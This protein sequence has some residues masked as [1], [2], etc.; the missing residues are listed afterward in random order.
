MYRAIDTP[1]L[2]A[3]LAGHDFGGQSL[4]LALE[5]RDSFL[6]ENDGETLLHFRDGLAELAPGAAPDVRLRLGVEHFSSLIMGAVGL[7]ALR[8]YGLAEI[9]DPNYSGRVRRLFDSPAQPI[10]LTAF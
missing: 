8:R 4:S 6:P 2:F 5:L 3:A 9:D 7:D 10:C 1:A